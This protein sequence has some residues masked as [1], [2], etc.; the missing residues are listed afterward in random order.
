MASER[1]GHVEERNP[2]VFE[3]DGNALVAG[4][5][6]QVVEVDRVA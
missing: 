5:L 2:Y 6:D 3:F 4:L 1:V